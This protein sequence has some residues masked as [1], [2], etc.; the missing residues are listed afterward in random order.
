MV[1]SI[2]HKQLRSRCHG[3]N[4]TCK[5][6]ANLGSFENDQSVK[7]CMESNS[8]NQ[9]PVVESDSSQRDAPETGNA[10]EK[11]NMLPP[12]KRHTI[13]AKMLD[14]LSG[15]RRNAILRGKRKA[16]NPYVLKAEA[17]LSKNSFKKASTPEAIAKCHMP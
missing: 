4:T 12:P 3:M 10:P 2:C 16:D 9:G 5:F 1:L 6:I 7:D 17:N 14:E 11:C 15:S 13:T 8:K